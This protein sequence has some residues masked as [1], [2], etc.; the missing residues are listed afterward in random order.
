MSSEIFE[1]RSSEMKKETPWLAAEDIV[2]LGD[3]T[4][5]IIACYRHK[6]VEFG[7]GRKEPLVYSVEFKGKK[8]QLVLN[9]TNRQVL[10]NAFGS[11][12]KKWKGQTVLLYVDPKVRLMGKLVPGI[13]IKLK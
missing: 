11:D 9:S 8:K 4:V 13:R 12:T 3:I 5:E 2:G 10:F 6:D 7:A 1:G